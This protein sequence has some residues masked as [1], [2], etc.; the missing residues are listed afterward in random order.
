MNPSHIFISHATNDKPFVTELRLA[1]EG[2]SLPVWVDSRN[3]RG[4]NKL[5][6]EIS[7]AIETA[8]QTIVVLSPNTV[9]SLWV[10]KEIQQALAVEQQKQAQGY[11]V[12]PLLLSGIEPSALALWFDEEPL[13]IRLTRPI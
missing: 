2:H 12:I 10:R 13:G 4:G 8:R 3:L 5:A 11:R 7:A 1:L 6:P 9:N